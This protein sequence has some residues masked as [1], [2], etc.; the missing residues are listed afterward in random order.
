[1]TGKLVSTGQHGNSHPRGTAA[2]LARHISGKDGIEQKRAAR[3]VLSGGCKANPDMLK[4]CEN[5]KALKYRSV[6]STDTGDTNW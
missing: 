3:L 5:S 6:P 2:N 4:M 1:M